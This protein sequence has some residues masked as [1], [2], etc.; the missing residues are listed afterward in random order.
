MRHLALGLPF[1]VVAAVVCSAGEYCRLERPLA[2]GRAA[3]RMA[4]VDTVVLHHT[5]LDSVGASLATL[6]RR[7]LSYHFVIDPDGRVIAA[8]PVARTALHAAGANSRSIGI[9]MVGGALSSWA[10]SEAQWKAAKALVGR[11]VHSYPGIRFLVGHGDVRDTNRGEPYGVDFRRFLA[12]LEADQHIRLWHP[13]PDEEPLRSFRAAALRLLERPLGPRNAR[14]AARLP[15]IE[16]VICPGNRTVL[17]SV[18]P[19]F[20]ERRQ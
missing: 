7:G 12:E 10:P 2:T 4:Q 20:Y 5:A 6:R 17:Y 3:R 14:P 18:P 9:S 19:V 11:L 15:Q 8:L 13:A 1:L 16:K